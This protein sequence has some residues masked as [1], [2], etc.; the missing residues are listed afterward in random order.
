[1]ALVTSVLMEA[2]SI[3]NGDQAA[4]YGSAL[5][6]FTQIGKLWEQ[7]LGV[8]VSPEKVALCLIQLK[9]SRALNNLEQ[10]GSLHRDSVVD[11]AGY[12]GCLEKIWKERGEETFQIGMALAR[13]GPPTS[14]VQGVSPA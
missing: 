13:E 5:K 1:M 11:I 14:F 4:T 2:E 12:T 9:V 8:A 10:D 3:I 7:V 6:S